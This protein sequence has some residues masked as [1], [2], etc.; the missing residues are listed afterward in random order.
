MILYSDTSVVIIHLVLSHYIAKTRADTAADDMC[1]IRYV[2][3]DENAV[4][5]LTAYIYQNN[6]YKSQRYL[7]FSYACE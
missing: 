1:Q 6:K 7:A 2:I 3:L 4:I 5:Y